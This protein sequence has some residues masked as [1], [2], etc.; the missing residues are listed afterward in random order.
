MHP[1]QSLTDSGKVIKFFL[2]QGVVPI[3]GCVFIPLFVESAL[4]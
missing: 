2:K 1:E 3:T 4:S